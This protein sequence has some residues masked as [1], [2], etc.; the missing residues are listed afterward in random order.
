MSWNECNHM[1]ERLEFIARLLAGE[2][3]A[4]VPPNRHLA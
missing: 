3:M 4:A 1:N 2:K